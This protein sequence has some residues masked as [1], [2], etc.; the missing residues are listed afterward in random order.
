MGTPD[1]VS[2]LTKQHQ[3]F[4]MKDRMDVLS[5][6]FFCVGMLISA[7]PF[8]YIA[9]NLNTVLE[10]LLGKNMTNVILDSADANPEF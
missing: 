10:V 2:V 6:E 4:Q 8:H 9:R 5:N 1:V 7:L 3:H